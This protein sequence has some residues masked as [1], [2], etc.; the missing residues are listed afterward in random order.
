MTDEPSGCVESLRIVQA[1]SFLLRA[2]VQP[3]RVDS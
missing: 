2:P 1:Q 3:L